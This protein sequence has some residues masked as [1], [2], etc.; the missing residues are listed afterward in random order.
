M[1]VATT[2][3]GCR[4]PEPR[5]RTRAK[6][7]RPSR[8]PARFALALPSSAPSVSPPGS[9]RPG[10]VGRSHATAP[11]LHRDYRQNETNPYRT[12]DQTRKDRGHTQLYPR[13]RH[14][15]ATGFPAGIQDASAENHAGFARSPNAGDCPVDISSEERGSQ[16]RRPTDSLV[17]ATSDP[18]IVAEVVEQSEWMRHPFATI[19]L[20]TA[21]AGGSVLRPLGTP[22]TIDSS[23]P[24]REVVD[25][26][27][28]IAEPPE[29][30]DP[31]PAPL[32]RPVF[33]RVRP[34]PRLGWPI[35]LAGFLGGV[36]GAIGYR[37][38]ERGRRH[39]YR[40]SPR[41]HCEPWWK[42]RSAKFR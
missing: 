28:A 12:H 26:S 40:R 15:T 5:P 2:P 6:R 19:R 33:P 34:T 21:A 42:W 9:R 22:W 1:S 32:L 14:E 4:N 16:A 38:F 36:V 35:V 25:A 18:A 17:V 29:P 27:A 30:I 10:R 8:E 11:S 37:E 23:H 3:G 20:E 39:F 41:P 13:L 24:A 31:K 7:P